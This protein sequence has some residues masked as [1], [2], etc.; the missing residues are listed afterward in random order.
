MRHWW[1]SSGHKVMWMIYLNLFLSLRDYLRIFSG[2][3][4]NFISQ[5]C[6]SSSQ[7]LWKSNIRIFFLKTCKFLTQILSNNICVKRQILP[8][9]K[10]L[11]F[12]FQRQ[13][14]NLLKLP[15]NTSA[16]ICCFICLNRDVRWRHIIWTRLLLANYLFKRIFGKRNK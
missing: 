12:W 6:G 2:F 7:K 9:K 10:L 16:N 8:L 5:A 3:S 11:H 14:K 1:I 13:L 15:I 4:L